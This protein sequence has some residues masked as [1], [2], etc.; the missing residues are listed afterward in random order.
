MKLNKTFVTIFL[1]IILWEIIFLLEIIKPIFL[2]SPLIVFTSLIKLAFTGD[3][4]KHIF[5]TLGRT[6]ISFFIS[7]LIGIPAGLLIGYFVKVRG[8][9]EFIIDFFRTMPSPA[10]IP[11]SLVILGIGDLSRITV[12]VFSISLIII[13]NTIYGVKNI[14]KTR[15]SVFKVLKSSKY[16]EFKKLILPEASPFIISGLRTALSINLIII[17]VTEMLIGTY[18]GLGFIIQTEQL[19]YNIPEMYS[20]IIVAGFIGFLLNKLF[21][22]I[23][24]RILFWVSN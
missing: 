19:M 20:Y 12:A 15:K 4:Y 3:F 16:Q 13:V 14:K 2:P 21:L 22:I 24:K 10:L 11:L 5:Y 8:Y 18:Y 17:I 7:A 23:E 6:F 1:L 9:F